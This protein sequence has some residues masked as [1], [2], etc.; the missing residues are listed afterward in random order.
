MPLM[1]ICSILKSLGLGGV[2]GFGSLSEEEE[3]CE[4]SDEGESGE[5][6]DDG[7]EV[8]GDEVGVDGVGGEGRERV[9]RCQSSDVEC[10]RYWIEGI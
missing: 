10:Q 8:E 6:D 3:E 2:R 5:G 9:G 4:E 1:L 7:E